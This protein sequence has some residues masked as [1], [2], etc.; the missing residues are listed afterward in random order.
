MPGMPPP[1]P[2]GAAPAPPAAGAGRPT[3][4]LGEIQAGRALRKTTTKDKSQAA[5]AGRVLD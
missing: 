3:A 5:V 1:P 2:P 4:L